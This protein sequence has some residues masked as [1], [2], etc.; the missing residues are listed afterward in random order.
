MRE[1]NVFS[2]KYIL[3]LQCNIFVHKCEQKC[4]L[5]YSEHIKINNI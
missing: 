1:T 4:L 5:C 2:F 3:L